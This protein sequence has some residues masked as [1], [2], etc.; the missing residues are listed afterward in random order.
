MSD[1]GLGSK[2]KGFL[3]KE[4]KTLAQEEKKVAGWFKKEERQL[5]SWLQRRKAD[6]A[7]KE[8]MKMQHELAMAK[9]QARQPVMVKETYPSMQREAPDYPP[10]PAFQSELQAMP[11]NEA[12]EDLAK[13]LDEIRQ[14]L[15][16]LKEEK[17]QDEILEEDK[18]IVD[19]L[20]RLE[21]EKKERSMK[22][23]KS[24]L[25]E[26]NGKSSFK[27]ARGIGKM[28]GMEFGGEGEASR[29]GSLASF[30]EH[31]NKFKAGESKEL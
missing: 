9:A 22:C 14:E 10:S 3:G 25:A 28:V 7:A 30:A 8:K 13:R 6:K 18:E 20:A 15:N 31:I 17:A 11:S 2:I 29:E 4:E 16:E 23:I 19:V 1:D 12:D 24:V 5:S 21:P 27:S 26:E